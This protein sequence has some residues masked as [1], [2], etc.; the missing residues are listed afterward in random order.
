[1]DAPATLSPESAQTLLDR[2]GQLDGEE[3]KA[4]LRFLKRTNDDLVGKLRMMKSEI[5]RVGRR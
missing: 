4:L 1:M 3:V 2:A 5:G